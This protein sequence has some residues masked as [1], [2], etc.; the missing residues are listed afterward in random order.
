M[1]VKNEEEYLP[2]CLSSVVRIVD[3]IIIVDTGSV[4]NTVAIAEAFGAKVIHMPWQ[5]SFSAA[6]NR[7]FEEARGEWILWL[8]AD[9][10][11]DVEEGDRLKELLTQA[12]VR[13]Q[14]I[15]CI[16][17]YFCNYLE[18]GGTEHVCLQR[19]VRNRP[20]YR[21]EGRIHEQILPS[22]LRANSDVKVGQVDIHIYHYGNLA[23]NIL[24]QDKTRRN[25]LLLLHSLREDSDY[26]KYHYYLGI[27][28]YRIHDLKNALQHFNSALTAPNG[29][30][31]TL[32]SSAHK[33][34]LI[35]LGA[36]RNDHALVQY[37]ME[38]ITLFPDFTDL[39]HLRASG[40]QALG[41]T[42]Q[43]IDSLRQALYRG[44]AHQE[45]PRMSGYGT[46][47][48]CAELGVLYALVEDLQNSDL[49]FTLASLMSGDARIRFRKCEVS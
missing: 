24:R 25:I 33:Y 11:M 14:N 39:Y 31:K 42:R 49:Y 17:F 18:G 4:D 6:R 46:Y 27:E 32:L 36:M 19:M 45:Y 7:C 40:L 29:F 34:R 15:E 41:Q 8:D 26:W 10:V 43:A 30:P 13:E 2:K 47:L 28:L 20:E 9:E 35:T 38:S 12:A 3:E 44:P 21:F 16:Q 23:K 5:D 37:S 48:T 22:M 1:I